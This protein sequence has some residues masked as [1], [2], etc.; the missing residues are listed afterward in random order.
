MKPTHEV[1]LLFVYAL[2]LTGQGCSDDGGETVD[3]GVDGDV[4]ADMDGDVDTDTDADVD[5][6]TDV[7]TDADI[8]GDTDGDS[9]TDADA[10]GGAGDGG[11]EC[12][13]WNL[14]IDV[15]PARMMLLQDI[16]LSMREGTPT[17]WSQAQEAILDLL[18]NFGFNDMLEIGFDVFPNSED[19]GA[20]APVVLDAAPN[21]AQAIYQALTR[22]ELV[23]STPM[24]TAMQNFLD[25][26]YAPVFSRGDMDSYL[27]LISDGKDVCGPPPG[28]LDING[29]ASPQ[30]IASVTRQLL[31]ERGIR[32][33][34]IGFGSAADPAQLN[35]VASNGGT[36]YTTYFQ[37]DDRAELEAVFNEIAAYAIS[38]EFTIDPKQTSVLAID[39]DKVN[40][41]FDGE[42]VGWDEGCKVGSG[43]NW[44]DDEKTT[45]RFCDQAC[46]AVKS[47]SVKDISATF[48]CDVYIIVPI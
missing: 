42:V 19:C 44:T 21:N 33:F 37:A 29:G 48:G 34:A 7:D 47:G 16:S 12:G 1:A 36:D 43:W 4:D 35:A 13:A 5:T 45:V 22:M 2:L 26:S 8:D 10:D 24:M 41:Y 11:D 32:T 46:E 38:C 9:D 23:L 28:V 18:N 31:D 20:D 40:F 25:P 3:T 6:D 30:E 14:E 27:V 15:R 39:K 17:K